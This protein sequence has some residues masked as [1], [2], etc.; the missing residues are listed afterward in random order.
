MKKKQK[1]KTELAVVLTEGKSLIHFQWNLTVKLKTL[2]DVM[3]PALNCETLTQEGS[4][5]RAWQVTA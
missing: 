1:T 4:C 3:I 2:I 5:K